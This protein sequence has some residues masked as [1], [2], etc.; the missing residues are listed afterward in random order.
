MGILRK[1]YILKIPVAPTKESAS[2]FLPMT[3]R[4]KVLRDNELEIVT[5]V[6]E[7]LPR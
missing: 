3:N 5:N 7:N 4:V 2:G 1:F 6:K